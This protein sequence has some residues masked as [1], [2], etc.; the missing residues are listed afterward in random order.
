[1]TKTSINAREQSLVKAVEQPRRDDMIEEDNF[2][3]PIRD[4]QT[5]VDHD[6]KG[7][8][9][10]RWSSRGNALA[11][12]GVDGFVRVYSNNGELKAK[13]KTTSCGE[14]V[15]TGPKLSLTNSIPPVTCLR[16]R[17]PNSRLSTK[18]VLA[19]SSSSG[20]DYWH[21]PSGKVIY[22]LNLGEGGEVYSMDYN[23]ESNKL[24][25]AGKDAT[26]RVVDEV[27]K[28]VELTLKRGILGC[29]GHTNRVF[30]TKFFGENQ[31]ISGGWDNTVIFWDIRAKDACTEVLF[32]PHICGETIATI[33]D[34]TLVTGA[35]AEE[36]QIQKW[37]MRTFKKLSN[38]PKAP[39][40]CKIYTLEQ[41]GGPNSEYCIA[42]G[43]GNSSLWA[44]GVFDG[45]KSRTTSLGSRRA[46]IFCSHTLNNRVALAGLSSGIRIFTIPAIVISSQRKVLVEP[47]FTE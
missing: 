25:C 11:V 1:M 7:F 20:I 6:F 39:P 18:E 35:Y 34:H 26:V 5:K 2:F 23:D 16:W 36:N 15:S 9:T 47:S 19:A 24:V 30:C 45:V 42:G 31:I 38:P 43:A 12:G 8:F 4:I 3:K 28:T 21:V 13:L 14:A 40:G 32:G 44:F 33:G 22:T 41:V 37:D 29:K 10:I 27:T 46:G 17:T